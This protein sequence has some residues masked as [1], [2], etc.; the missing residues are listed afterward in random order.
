MPQVRSPRRGSLQYW[1][2]KRAKHV[3]IRAWAATPEAKPLGFAGYKVGM[4]HIMAADNRKFSLTKGEDIFVPVTIIECPPIKVAALVFFRN[5]LPVG[6]TFA[7]SLDKELARAISLPK[8]KEQRAAPAHDD[9]RLLAYTQPKLTS[10]KKKPDVFELRIGG[11]PEER[12][13]DAQEILG[14]EIR[15]EDIFKEGQQVDVHAITKGKGFQGTVKRFGVKIMQHKAEKK[16]RG[17]ANVG[18]WTPKRVQFTAP[19]PGKMGYHLRTELNKWIIRLAKPEEINARAGFRGY[20]LV[21]N[22][23]LLLKGSTAGAPKRLVKL[24]NALRPDALVPREAPSVGY[25]GT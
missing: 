23:C 7:A 18:S 8:T 11:P 15:P 24:T 25:I 12:M 17:N 3:R 9:V 20:G 13:R 5:N 21:K 2:R 10:V 19:M 4:T 16:K 14:K 22:P 6:Q 1:P